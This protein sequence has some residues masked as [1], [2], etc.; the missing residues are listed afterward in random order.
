M[1]TTAS[2]DPLRMKKRRRSS[3]LHHHT[4]TMVCCALNETT[5]KN[6][7]HDIKSTSLLQE[8]EN[9]LVCSFSHTQPPFS[10]IVDGSLNK[11]MGATTGRPFPLNKALDIG[12]SKPFND[13]QA[14][15]KEDDDRMGFALLCIDIDGEYVALKDVR[16]KQMQA[17]NKEL[18]AAADNIE[19]F[20]C[21]KRNKS[22]TSAKKADEVN[23]DEK[24]LDGQKNY[25]SD[26]STSGCG[27]DEVEE[28]TEACSSARRP[29]PKRETDQDDNGRFLYGY[30]EP[31]P[32]RQL[33]VLEHGD[34]I[35][36]RYSSETGVSLM[37][38]EYAYGH[39]DHLFLEQREAGKVNHASVLDV[40]P[41]PLLN[42]T[43]KA[44]GSNMNDYE[45]HITRK[46]RDDYDDND[47]DDEVVEKDSCISR[48]VAIKDPDHVPAITGIEVANVALEQK[49]V[50][51]AQDAKVSE[52]KDVP[53]T[54]AVVAG[55]AHYTETSDDNVGTGVLF[56]EDGV[57]Q[58]EHEESQTAPFFTA[59]DHE[60]ESIDDELSGEEL[61]SPVKS[62]SK[63]DE[64]VR[65]AVQ[66][67]SDVLVT[68][69]AGSAVADKDGEDGDDSVTDYSLTQPYPVPRFASE[70]RR[71]SSSSSTGEDDDESTV[72]PEAESLQPEPEDS[73]LPPIDSKE[74]EEEVDVYNEPT[75][76]FQY[77]PKSTES[78]NQSEDD[79]Q[80][81][82]QFEMITSSKKESNRRDENEANTISV[83]DNHDNLGIINQEIAEEPEPAEKHLTAEENKSEAPEMGRDA[84]TSEDL[85]DNTKRSST[86]DSEHE[87]HCDGNELGRSKNSEAA[88]PG[89]VREIVANIDTA[90]AAPK[91]DDTEETV[92][93]IDDANGVSNEVD[94]P[95]HAP[96]GRKRRESHN[97]DPPAEISVSVTPRQRASRKRGTPTSARH[98]DSKEAVR[99]MFTGLAPTKKHKQVSSLLRSCTSFLVCVFYFISLQP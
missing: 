60:D 78:C 96:A 28:L 91:S 6:E 9:W 21:R 8:G 43:T 15:S 62:P 45:E 2:S 38:F 76:P 54:S 52:G 35:L 20:I 40:Q 47:D 99:V 31:L 83:I 17:T 77:A 1:A 32:R 74:D 79:Y 46:D 66:F 23:V 39:Q 4:M 88:I 70:Q 82:T 33:R 56:E 87:K 58:T 84:T 51:D 64:S 25:S 34:R 27:T 95:D 44:D 53:S 63:E 18:K 19:L 73:K 24:H 57:K 29:P 94:G 42:K 36:L 11:I 12:S 65:H 22:Q 55:G 98:K 26:E 41:Q 7:D 90:S 71:S 37:K 86:N 69:A 68:A 16:Q 14:P 67:D 13:T 10:C 92:C 49:E 30:P 59:P 72:C 93:Q 85:D 50:G 61:L 80:A 81:E 3:H 48:V 89:P 75:Q 97:T 5:A